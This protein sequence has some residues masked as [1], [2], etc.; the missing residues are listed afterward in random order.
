M[1]TSINKRKPLGC[2]TNTVPSTIK[3]IQKRTRI[4]ATLLMPQLTD[5][6]PGTIYLQNK[7]PCLRCSR[8]I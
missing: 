3:D 4:D 8:T 2:V 7:L 5:I 6:Q 1:L